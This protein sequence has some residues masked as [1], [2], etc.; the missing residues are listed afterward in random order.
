MTWVLGRDVPGLLDNDFPLPLDGPFTIA[1]AV[2]AGASR[3]VIGRLVE[4]GLLRRILK[5]VYVAAQVPDDLLLRARALGLVVPADATIVDWTACWLHAGVLPPGDHLRVPPVSMFRSAGRGRLRN[6]LCTSGERTFQERDLA[7]VGNLVVTTPLRTVLDLGRL[8]SRDWA[9][10][11]MDALLRHGGVR[12]EELLDEIE[13]FRRQRGVVQL[14]DLA[15]RADGRAESPGESVLRLRWTDLRTLPQP[16]P[17]VPI[18]GPDGREI[19]RIDLGVEDLLF[20]AEY[21]GEEY[22][23]SETD[24]DHDVARRRDLDRSFGWLV[25]SVRREN[26]FGATRDVERILHEGLAEARRRLARFRST[27]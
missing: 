21:D 10:A 5:G 4:L 6:N 2:R 18:C 15:P 25:K 12:R 16:E 19:Y 8:A 9:L 26:V 13:R 14:R 17:Q 11:G 20:G 1:Q 22:H 23:S 27:G 24:R 3:F 7:V